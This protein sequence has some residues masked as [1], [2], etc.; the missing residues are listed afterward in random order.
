MRIL[1]TWVGVDRAWCD[2]VKADGWGGLIQGAFSGGMAEPLFPTMQTECENS[3]RN[4]RA[5]GLLTAA[6]TNASPWYSV[7]QCIQWTLDAIGDELDNLSFLVVDHELQGSDVQYA[8]YYAGRPT[9]EW[10]DEFI[11]KLKALGKPLIG[12]SGDWFNGMRKAHGYKWQWPELLFGYWHARYD[13]VPDVKVWPPLHPMHA[14][15][16]GK[17]FTGSTIIRGKTVDQNEFDQVWIDSLTQE[18]DDMSS[19]EYKELKADID[20][21]K[22]LSENYIVFKGH[23]PVYRQSGHM[24][25]HVEDP[26]QMRALAHLAK[27]EGWG[28]LIRVVSKTDPDWQAY[29]DMTTV[30]QKVPEKYRPTS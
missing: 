17:Q 13:G 8:G 23:S 4:A 10:M 12:Y 18:E 19:E 6:Y 27:G 15:V 5:A 7:D 9:D 24:L 11:T 16:I 28:H 20:R 22:Q 3:L 30:Y 29:K 26:A 2:G 1:D 14:L 25:I 21:L